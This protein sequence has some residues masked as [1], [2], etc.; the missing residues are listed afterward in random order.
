MSYGDLQWTPFVLNCK[1]KTCVHS[2]KNNYLR[3][4]PYVN[5]INCVGC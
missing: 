4:Q 2:C 5:K 3:K 1:N